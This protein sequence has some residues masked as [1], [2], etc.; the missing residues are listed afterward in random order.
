MSKFIMKKFSLLSESWYLLSKKQK[1]RPLRIIR[2]VR[3]K[4]SQWKKKHEGDETMRSGPSAPSTRA[5]KLKREENMANPA[6]LCPKQK[7]PVVSKIK[8]MY[9]H[10]EKMKK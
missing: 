4:S 9:P 2:P 6:R 8:N 3:F 1:N 5:R 10:E 7:H